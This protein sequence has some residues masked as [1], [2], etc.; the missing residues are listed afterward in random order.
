MNNMSVSLLSQV[1][2]S[3]ELFVK[4]IEDTLGKYGAGWEDIVIRFEWDEIKKAIQRDSSLPAL[5]REN[6]LALI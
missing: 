1:S 3:F 6:A 4:A 2:E 5:V